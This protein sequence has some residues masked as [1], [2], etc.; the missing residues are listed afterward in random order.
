MTAMRFAFFL[1]AAAAALSAAGP[2]RVLESNPRWLTD[3]SGRAIYLTGSHIWQ[4]LQDSGLLMERGA[5]NPPP[6]FDFDAYLDFLEK[7][8]HN[9]IR[10][11]RWEPSRFTDDID[12]PSVVKYCRPHPWPRTG[13]GMARD[14]APKFDLERF[15]PE[16][17]DRL[18][19]RV[20]AAG[21]RGIWVSVMLFEGWGLQFMD[22]WDYH[23]FNAA[24]NI[25]GVGGDKLD[26]VGLKNPRFTALQ[27]AYV[28]K[29]VDTVNGFDNVLYEIAN[30]SG[31]HST[32]WQY[33]MIRYVKQRQAGKPRQHLVGMT[34][35]YRGGANKT[36]F[37][38]PADWISPNSTPEENYIDNPPSKY[39]GKVV[40]SDT[41]HL[42]GKSGGDNVWVWKSFMRGLH[43]LLMEEL[44]PSPTWQDSA[45]D[46]MGQ[47]RRWSERVNLAAMTPADEVSQTRYCL[48]DRG[49]EY[50]VFQKGDQG[51]FRVNLK[52]AP[53]RFAVEWF[54]VNTGASLP[55]RPVEGGASRTFATPF[56][57]PAV[58]Y[59]KRM[60]SP[61]PPSTPRRQ[62]PGEAP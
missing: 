21:E 18:R 32:E 12:P 37:D 57:G 40:L 30:E 47:T 53:G 25:N 10:L 16:Y 27:E 5:Q 59:L 14:G 2:L 29:V 43:T 24:N 13:P 41:D 8:G 56:G 35:Q 3:G 48:A 20:A 42:W 7:R 45:R 9:F 50:L 46:A 58:L 38:S 15:D 33:H 23:P 54:N 36:L 4:S 28:R 6:V 26:Y 51:E 52:E 49:R 31:A 60:A 34:F 19:A 17:F 62:V 39:S 61:E 55:G 11:W 44:T 22:A 1:A